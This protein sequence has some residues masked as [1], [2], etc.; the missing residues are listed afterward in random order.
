ME[1]TGLNETNE[2]LRQALAL[3]G[4]EPRRALETLET[5][6]Q[7]ARQRADW[8]GVSSLAR[9]AATISTELGD[10]AAAITYY[11]EALIGSSKDGYL[12][13]SIGCVRKTLRQNEEART[14]FTIS[15]EL[16]KKDGDIDLTTMAS[17]ALADLDADTF[18]L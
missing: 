8:A 7:K 3:A 12:H 11:D 15:L 17:R 4:A 13:F 10:F 9:H 1:G 18:E 6:L 2:T 14:A 16:A 5:G